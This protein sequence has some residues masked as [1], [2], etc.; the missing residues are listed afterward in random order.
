MDVIIT[1]HRH[2][3]LVDMLTEVNKRVADMQMNILMLNSHFKF[4]LQVTHLESK[5]FYKGLTRVIATE[6][7]CDN[8]DSV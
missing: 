6:N 2:H 8:P 7:V 3:H 1:C 4:Q 5:C